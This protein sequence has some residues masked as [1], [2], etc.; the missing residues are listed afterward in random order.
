LYMDGAYKSMSM[1]T[2]R[3]KFTMQIRYPKATKA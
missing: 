3:M 2:R 1:S